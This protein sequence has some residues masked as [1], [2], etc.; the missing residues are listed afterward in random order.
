MIPGHPH[1][2]NHEDSANTSS[3]SFPSTPP[4]LT[5]NLLTRIDQNALSKLSFLTLPT[6]T[7]AGDQ[8]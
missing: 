6:L 3:P 7:F 5:I 8:P 1:Y 4:L 2:P